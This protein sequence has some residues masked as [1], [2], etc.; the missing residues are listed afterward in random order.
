MPTLTD[1]ELEELKALAQAATP[2]PWHAGHL[3]RDDLECNCPYVLDEGHAGGIAT[4]HVTNNLPISEGGNDAPSL[5]EAKANQRFIATFNPEMILALLSSY[6]ERGRALEAMRAA[7]GDPM[8]RRALGGHNERQ[9][10]AMT[11]ARASLS[12]TSGGGE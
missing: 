9:Q 1:R 8:T 12:P 2:G 5:E 10:L 7:F 4:V 6:E 3:C 11:Q